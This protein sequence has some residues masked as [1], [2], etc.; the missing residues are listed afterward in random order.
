MIFSCSTPKLGLPQYHFSNIDLLV[1]ILIQPFEMTIT[2]HLPVLYLQVNL[3]HLFSGFDP[4]NRSRAVINFGGPVSTELRVW[5]WNTMIFFENFVTKIRTER[6]VYLSFMPEA[7]TVVFTG[8]IA[9]TC[10]VGIDDHSTVPLT[11]SDSLTS[12]TIMSF[13]TQTLACGL[14][15]T[16]RAS[17][18]NIV[19]ILT[20]LPVGESWQVLNARVLPYMSRG[21]PWKHLSIY[22]VCSNT[23]TPS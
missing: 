17:D 13:R 16:A 15:S 2:L 8:L 11:L 10:S 7:E 20:F 12:G 4:V 1:C 5:W 21:I 3:N 19:L 6:L 14:R 23:L 18:I 9:P 22:G